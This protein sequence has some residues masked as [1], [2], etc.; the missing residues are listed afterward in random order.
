MSDEA[1]D[2]F[3]NLEKH[4]EDAQN[5]TTAPNDNRPV[6]NKIDIIDEA[7]MLTQGDSRDWP[8]YLNMF[9]EKEVNPTNVLAFFNSFKGH[10]Y[11]D[12][13]VTEHT[14]KKDGRK[15][16]AFESI[17]SYY[18]PYFLYYPDTN[19]FK[20]YDWDKRDWTPEFKFKSFQELK[21]DDNNFW[22]KR[23]EQHVKWQQEEIAKYGPI[24]VD[25]IKI[26]DEWQASVDRVGWI[27]FEVWLD[28]RPIYSAYFN[29]QD[30]RKK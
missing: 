19:T 10:F 7:I 12:V 25:K 28:D 3:A 22:N 13:Y 9:D 11:Q 27:P 15:F 30:S 5:V 16:Y 23:I 6:E 1:D 8:I 2:F 17:E 4:C 20:D 14:D 26:F 18:P 21:A 29:R 24:T